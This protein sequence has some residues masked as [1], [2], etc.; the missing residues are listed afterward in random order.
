MKSGAWTVAALA[1]LGPAAAFASANYPGAVRSELGSEAVPACTLCH[2]TLAG[3]AGT[4]N[5]KFGVSVREA[6]LTG[7]GNTAAL[8]TSLSALET[9]AKDSDVDGEPDIAE[10]KAGTD[11][12][13]GGGEEPP[14]RPEYGCHLAGGS[15]LLALLALATWRRPRRPAR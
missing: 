14:L 12:N 2:V 9:S 13:V 8:A 15:P 1:L 11:P 7:G 3:G 6:G 10:L 4:V 5:T